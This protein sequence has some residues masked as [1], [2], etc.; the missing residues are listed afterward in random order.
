MVCAFQP[1]QQGALP[2]TESN[3]Q[4]QMTT[5]TC[6]RSH[7]FVPISP[8]IPIRRLRKLVFCAASLYVFVTLVPS[9]LSDFYRV[10]TQKV[11]YLSRRL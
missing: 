10:V 6:K 3:D 8:T 11:T 4:I 1:L 2:L 5:C 9:G 7:T